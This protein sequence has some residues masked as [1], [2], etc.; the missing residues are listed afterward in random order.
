MDVFRKWQSIDKFSDAYK[1]ANRNQVTSLTYNAKI[2][3]HG[4]NAGIRVLEDGSL[5]AQKRT[6]DITPEND[7]AG[8][9][10]FVASLPTSTPMCRGTVIYG[11][12]A[13]KGVQKTDAVSQSE[14]TFYVFAID[15]D[16][17][18]SD[19]V[20]R[21][22]NDPETITNFMK[23][24]FECNIPDGI[25][26]IPWFYDEDIVVDVDD[27]S[28]AQQFIDS[29]TSDVDAIGVFD[30]YIKSLYGIEAPGEGLVYYCMD[31]GSAVRKTLHISRVEEY[32]KGYMFKHKTAEH[33]VNKSKNRSHVAPEKPAGIDE[34]IEMF[35]TE[36]R[37]E[38]MVND[39]A[40]EFDVKNT[41]AFMK[42]VM[43]DIHKESVNEI[44]AA[45]FEWK[46]ATKYLPQTVRGWWLKKC[47]EL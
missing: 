32:C 10:R 4:T 31:F 29:A 47:N 43:S 17:I 13:G 28:A 20:Y 18:F 41:G 27:Q 30:P 2:K 45:D 1:L 15:T 11:E 35:A 22:I 14:K 7:N 23:I 38:Q 37:F 12:W 6:G 33:S 44:E 25:K 19:R 3:L 42:A 24:V 46:D 16:H 26:V 21:R 39:N 5:Q 40:I 8:F 36:R 9:A 34:F